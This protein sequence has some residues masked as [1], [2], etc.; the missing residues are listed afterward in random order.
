MNIKE[1]ESAIALEPI[2]RYKHFIKRVADSEVFFTLTDGNS[3]YALSE[4]EGQKLFPLWSAAEYAELCKI[5]GWDGFL[6]KEL[7]LDDL[8]DEI[9]DFIA[10]EGC[11]VNVFPVY[12]KTGFVVSIT[13]FARDLG[14][15]LKNYS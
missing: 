9:I 10:D 13:E 2:E 6:I 12:D 1:T 4:L 11:L 3:H 8:E 7:D 5:N 14:D 15:E